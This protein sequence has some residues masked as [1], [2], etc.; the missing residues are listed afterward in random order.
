VSKTPK[1]V[2]PPLKIKINSKNKLE[3]QDGFRFPR[4]AH[5]KYKNKLPKVRLSQIFFCTSRHTFIFN[6]ADNT[7]NMS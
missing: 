6:D 7:E 4:T 2:V 5:N 1:R 3:D